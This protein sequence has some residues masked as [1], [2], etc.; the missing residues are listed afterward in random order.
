MSS[1]EL[2]EEGGSRQRKTTGGGAVWKTK[3]ITKKMAKH[4]LPGDSVILRG[5]EPT[6]NAKPLLY[7]FPTAILLVYGEGISWMQET[8]TVLADGTLYNGPEFATC[9]P[10]KRCEAAKIR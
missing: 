1:K 7:F 3:N 4:Q 9:Q 2:K 8:P 6:K 5:S 10:A